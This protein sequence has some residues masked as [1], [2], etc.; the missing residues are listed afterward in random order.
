MSTC[1]MCEKLD[2]LCD[3]HNICWACHPAVWKLKHE[4]EFEREGTDHFK[5]KSDA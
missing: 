1:P 3:E 4:R 2:T 5:V